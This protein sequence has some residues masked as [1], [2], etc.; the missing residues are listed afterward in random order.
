MIDN[1]N[2]PPAPPLSP[3][4]YLCNLDY[5]KLGEKL[6]KLENSPRRSK[7]E[8]EQ[9]R[10]K[11]IQ[12]IVKANKIRSMQPLYKYLKD[13]SFI[14][15]VN[16]SKQRI[17]FQKLKKEIIRK[18]WLRLRTGILNNYRNNRFDSKAIKV[19]GV[20]IKQTSLYL[21][22]N[23]TS[24][25]DPDFSALLKLS[26]PPSLEPIHSL[27]GN[28]PFENEPKILNEESA[29]KF[30]HKST[31]KFT[32]KKPIFKK[33]ALKLYCAFI[34][35]GL[36]IGY[37]LYRCYHQKLYSFLKLKDSEIQQMTIM[38][39]DEDSSFTNIKGPSQD[40]I[41]QNIADEVKTA[42]NTAD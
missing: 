27:R 5:S 24:Y 7:S 1:N 31:Q 6:D 41:F 42:T 11:W 26:I 2:N 18:K 29:K 19:R 36:I 9:S 3:R 14:Q 12:L 28:G 4:R 38:P 20:R 10:F 35:I 15:S 40:S 22:T 34:L 16:V 25:I 33:E 30:K 8:R 37:I 32:Q 13:E 17:Y 39:K 21:T 23:D